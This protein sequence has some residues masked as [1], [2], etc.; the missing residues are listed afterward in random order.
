MTRRFNVEMRQKIMKNKKD[1]TL[2]FMKGKKIMKI[3]VERILN[4]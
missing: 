3:N 1:K 2:E 4:L